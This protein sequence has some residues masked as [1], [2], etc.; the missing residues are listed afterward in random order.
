V[1]T[2]LFPHD[3]LVERGAQVQKLLEQGCKQWGGN[4]GDAALKVLGLHPSLYHAKLA[5]R[6]TSAGEGLGCSGPS[7]VRKHE[8]NVLEEV[9]YEVLILAADL[10][11][12]E[13][14][15]VHQ[16]GLQLVG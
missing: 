7:F 2:D 10:P 16:L 13:P 8:N 3:S 15:P 12:V 5:T 6:R 14:A 11:Y 9:A 1:P 4:R